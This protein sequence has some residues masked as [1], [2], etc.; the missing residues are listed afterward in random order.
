MKNISCFAERFQMDR[1]REATEGQRN[2]LLGM[3]GTQG[4]RNARA[5]CVCVCVCVCCVVCVCVHVSVCII[6]GTMNNKLFSM[7]YFFFKFSTHEFE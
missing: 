5:V 7:F 3:S 2:S 4:G 6:A 1:R